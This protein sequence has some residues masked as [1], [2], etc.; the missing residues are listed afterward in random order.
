MHDCHHLMNLLFQCLHGSRKLIR[1]RLSAGFRW[2]GSALLS[3]VAQGS[4]YIL[5]DSDPVLP[6]D[7]SGTTE[8][9]LA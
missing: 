9:H 8:N 1:P 7:V 4:I 5:C 6:F 3:S 2:C